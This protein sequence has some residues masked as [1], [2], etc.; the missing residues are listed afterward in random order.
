MILVMCLPSLTEAFFSDI[1]LFSV[2]FEVEDTQQQPPIRYAMKVQPGGIR[3]QRELKF[4]G[5]IRSSHVVKLLQGDLPLPFCR[6][7][8]ALRT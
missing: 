5:E 2:V 3:F 8:V 1:D 6:M 4:M 7:D